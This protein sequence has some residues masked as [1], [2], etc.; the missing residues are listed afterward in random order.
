M[1]DHELRVQEDMVNGF[2]ELGGLE[3]D[4]GDI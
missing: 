1:N 2:Q 4:L 3:V